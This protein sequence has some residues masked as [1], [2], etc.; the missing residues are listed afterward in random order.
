MPE[1]VTIP[2]SFFE[3]VVDYIRP[4]LNL[5]ADRA[6]I[7]QGIFDVL[8]PWNLSVD[9]VEPITT[10]KI[11]EQGV[12]FKLPLKR[13]LFFFG[14]ASCRFT[15]D[16]VDWD[17]AE[18]TLAILDAVLSALVQLSSVAMVT[19]KT[20]VG[21]HIQPR[22]MSFME[23]LNPFLAPQLA[24]LESE[25][26]KTM[27]TVAKWGKRKVTLDGSGSLANGVFLKFEREF[28]SATTYQEIAE[29]LRRDEEELF[30]ILG[31]EEDR[32]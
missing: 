22:T 29:Q 25:P 31:V 16:A 12:T 32:G 9:D 15:R 19:K 17:S 20:A 26:V 30:R 1:L 4:D 8:K 2:I 5:L 23:I 6:P 18:E 13:V 28:E 21:V 3:L 11:S 24:A 27:A 10:G 7:V 14:A